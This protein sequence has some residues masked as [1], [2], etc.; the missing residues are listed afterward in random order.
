MFTSYTGVAG[1]SIDAGVSSG[2]NG[3]QSGGGILFASSQVTLV[4]ITD[5]TSN[6]LLVGEQSNHLRDVNNQ[7]IPGAFGAITSQGPHGWTM[8]SGNA[9]VG[10]AYTDRH[11]NCS[12]TAYTINQKGLPNSGGTAENTGNNI[13][14]S[15]GHSG[16][17]N[18][19]MGD[20]SVRFMT[21]STAL[22]TLQWM[23]SRAGGEVIANQ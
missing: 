21:D 16:G 5:G 22:L 14:L 8:G 9:A 17:A 23:S 7:A 6:T 15:S 4:G 1:S 3:V 20:G 11:F 13:P 12:T 2:A 10:A 18:M 19:L